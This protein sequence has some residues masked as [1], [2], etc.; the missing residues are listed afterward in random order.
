MSCI[1]KVK[2]L[3][4]EFELEFSMDD[5]NQKIFID[6]LLKYCGLSMTVLAAVLDISTETMSATH[7]GEILLKQSDANN[8]MIIF[9]T[10]F[11][12]NQFC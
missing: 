3:H 2:L 11:G 7:K 12:G 10:F 8:L 5:Q 1:E 6:A 4:D 9:L